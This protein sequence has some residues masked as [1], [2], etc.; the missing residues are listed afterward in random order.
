M[1]QEAFENLSD[2]E[3]GLP[4]N[5]LIGCFIAGL[6]DEIRLDVKIKQPN[7]LIDAI[8]VARLVEERN[9]LHQNPQPFY[10]QNTPINLR[11]TTTSTSGTM[12]AHMEGGSTTRPP[13]LTG[14]NY[15]YWK[16]K[17]KMFIKS[18]DEDAWRTVLTGSKRLVAT[19]EKGIQTEKHEKDWSK[20]EQFAANMN[21]KALNA[22]F[23]GVDINQFKIISACECAKEAWEKLQTA[24][25]GTTSVRLSKL[26][27]LAT[28]FEDLRMEETET[29]RDFNS[30][31]CDIAN[32]AHGLGETY[33]EVKL[34]RKVL[35]SMPDRFAYKVTAI[36]EASD[37][38]SLRLEDLIGNLQTFE[39][40][41]NISRMD[42]ERKIALQTVSVVTPSVP[43]APMTA[44]EVKLTKSMSLIAKNFGKLVKMNG[45]PR[46]PTNKQEVRKG[47]RCRECRGYGHIQAECANT[48]KKQGKSLATT[49][50]DDNF[51]SDDES[52][53][54]DAETSIDFCGTCR[55]TGVTQNDVTCTEP[56]HLRYATRNLENH[57]NLNTIF[58]PTGKEDSEDDEECSIEMIQQQLNDLLKQ[59]HEVGD[60][61]KRLKEKVKELE[62]ENEAVKVNL[63]A[64]IDELE[65]ENETRHIKKNP[66]PCLNLKC[67]NSLVPTT[68]EA[69]VSKLNRTTILPSNRLDEILN[70]HP[71]NP[72]KLGLGYIGSKF[73][74]KPNPNRK[75]NFV[76]NTVKPTLEHVASQSY[77][78]K[79]VP[80]CHFCHKVGHVRP[81]CFKRWKLINKSFA[82][83]SSN[84]AAWDH[85]S[86]RRY[87]DNKWMNKYNANCFPAI[88]SLKACTTNSWYF[89]SGCSKHMTG[90]PNQ[91]KNLQNVSGGQV[92]LGDG[93]KALVKGEGN[94]D[95]GG[96]P[97]LDNVLYVEG[98]KSN[99]LSVSQLCDLY[100][101]VLFTKRKCEVFDR[102]HMCVLSG[103]RSS[104]NCYKIDQTD[105][106]EQCP[107]A[108]SDITD[109]CYHRLGN[110]NFQ[111]L[112]RNINAGC[113]K[114]VPQLNSNTPDLCGELLM[115]KQTKSIG[116][117]IPKDRIT[118]VSVPTSY[119]TTEDVTTGKEGMKTCNKPK[120][121]YQE[122]V[123]Y[124]YL[125][126]I[127]E[128]KNIKEAILDEFW[129]LAKLEE[130]EQFSRNDMW[131]LVLSNDKVKQLDDEIFISQSKYAKNVVSKFGLKR[132]KPLTTRMTS[133]EKLGRDC[134]GTDV[135]STLHRILIGSLFHLSANRYDICFSVGICAR[136]KA[137]PK[138]SHLSAVNRIIRCV[139]GTPELRKWYSKYT[140]NCLAGNSDADW[141]G[142]VDNRKNI[143]GD[144]FYMVSHDR[145]V[146]PPLSGVINVYDLIHLEDHTSIGRIMLPHMHL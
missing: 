68:L 140:N 42:K 84:P 40:K 67:D 43:S 63:K 74:G 110:L 130:L 100:D 48:H 55:V 111:D 56:P 133:I 11:V 39:N 142:D 114:G 32:E 129:V 88:L 92:T 31:L 10:S 71:S 52:E 65:L 9:M 143:T 35:R 23:N 27:M 30:K 116:R 141:T 137:S 113:V 59:C 79:F 124:V 136:Y 93:N 112:T 69:S 36:E 83:Q 123:R 91:L 125:T 1:Y 16:T 64:K 121:D 86:Q 25:E 53:A 18:M 108:T 98:L 51:E 34:V 57:R 119:V 76:N 81:K 3:D 103:Y 72:D 128:P 145:S 87:S 70:A 75:I 29:V 77:T 60:E 139:S 61:N 37:V 117:E 33:P 17:M 47:I 99:L 5:F 8:G 118:E 62:E 45:H 107:L 66:E 78:K 46:S 54:S 2:Q 146:L 82:Y 58:L 105:Q 132:A 6:S 115:G 95:V 7:S 109:M 26:Q 104:D 15:S 80:T 41:L 138:E 122:M 12:N 120:V 101:S 14:T 144:C 73:D 28:R 22:I 126:S 21:S 90:V 127:V 85:N 49:W 134:D 19:D 44:L 135:D 50:S 96:L 131:E 94:L 97:N 13:L 38:D 4:E 24:Y 106:V 20:T 89:D 102:N